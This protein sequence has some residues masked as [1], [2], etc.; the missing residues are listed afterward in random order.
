M[1]KAQVEENRM[2]SDHKLAYA[3]KQQEKRMNSELS[4]LR[5]K[6][7]REKSTLED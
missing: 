7:R 1:L 4:K 3:M 6:H 2:D 5:S